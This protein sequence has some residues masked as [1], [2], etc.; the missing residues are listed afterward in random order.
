MLPTASPIRAARPAKSTPIN[1]PSALPAWPKP[2]TPIT[3]VRRPGRS[4]RP[5]TISSSPIPAI[6]GSRCS[7]PARSPWSRP[8]ARPRRGRQRQCPSG[9]AWQSVGFDPATGHILV[10]D[11]GN[12]RIQI[13][14]A[15]SFG[16]VAT[17]GATGTTATDNAHFNQPAAVHLNPTTR[18]LYV[19]DTGNDR[20]QVFDADTLAYIATIG[21]SGVAGSDNAHLNQPKDAE[22]NPSANQIMVADS[23][24]G[25]LQL[26]DA[27]SLAYAATLGGPGLG[28][29]D[30]D[31]LGTPGTAAFDPASNLVLVA[32]TGA[33]ARVQ[34]FDAMTYAYVLTLGTTG[35]S[36]AGNSQFAGPSGIAADPAHSRMFIGDRLND[37]IQVYAIG[38]AV[39]FASVLPGSRSVLLGTPAT[40]FASMINAGT[41]SLGGCQVALPVTAPAGLTLSYQTTNPATNGLTG[42]PNTP[43]TIAPN[44]GVQSFLVSLQGTTPFVAAAMTLDF[45]CTGAAPAAVITGVDTLD[46]T[47]SSHADRRHHRAGG[48]TERKR[49]CRDPGGRGCRLRRRQQQCRC[50]LPHH[51]LG[52]YRQCDPAA[53]CRDLPVQPRHRAVPGHAC[54]LG[55]AQ[56]RGRWDPD[57][58]GVPAG[59]RGDP[60]RSGPCPHLRALQGRR[61]RVAWFDQRRDPGELSH[62]GQTF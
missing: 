59:E 1:P 52:R 55:A 35:S 28:T 12:D 7:I 46:L 56:F 15:K 50:R 30:N 29:A 13:F 57:L 16:F 45:D 58:L 25:R 36:G 60:A 27:G 22:F 11:S 6:S 39:S 20:V 43:A 4:I 9:R 2:T 38:P 42:T 18:E 44:D 17:L 48:D 47:L 19:A 32:D 54:R 24:N 61:W 37:R 41:T 40:I 26:F 53:H 8:S 23:G 62:S 51:R 34:V 14:D 31:Y 21:S 5:T 49:H 33:D 10:A 3:A